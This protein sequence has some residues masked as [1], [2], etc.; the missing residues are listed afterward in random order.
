MEERGQLLTALLDY[1]NNGILPNF[2]GSLKMI[3][4]CIKPNID[5]DIDKYVSRCNKN[6]ENI[7]KRYER[8]QSNTTEYDRIQSK[9]NKIKENKINK[10]NKEKNIKKE[11]PQIPD[12]ISEEWAAFAEMR[13]KIKK[14]LTD[15]SITMALNKLKELANNDCELQ[16]RILNQSTFNCWS[17]LYPLKEQSFNGFNKPQKAEEEFKIGENF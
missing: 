5:A 2:S 16:R 8:I 1:G 13:K 11:S 6:K 9:V 12:E 14:P 17:S 7:A 4:D 3:F 10:N 15:R